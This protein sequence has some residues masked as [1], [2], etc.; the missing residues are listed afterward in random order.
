VALVPILHGSG[1]RIKALEAWAHGVTVVGTSRGLDGLGAVHGDNAV[2]ADDPV[3]MAGAL[4]A[5]L[6]DPAEARRIGDAGRRHVEAGASMERSAAVIG[7]LVQRC[8]AERA[9]PGLRVA[10]HLRLTEVDDGIAVHDP[11][12][13]AVHHLDPMT[14]IAATLADGLM[15]MRQLVDAVAGV[16][17]GSAI[18][19]AAA[20]VD[21]LVDHHLV[22]RCYDGMPPNAAALVR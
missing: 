5:V 19:A 22:V 17:G 20:A 8:L 3:T 7:E 11:L 21:L 4:A 16:V 18:D 15:T 2:I 6:D 10:A 9:E 1:S 14:S 13:G 12:L